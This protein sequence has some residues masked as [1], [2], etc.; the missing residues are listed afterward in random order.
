MPENTL[1]MLA[2]GTVYPVGHASKLRQVKYEISV[3]IKN[4]SVKL[5]S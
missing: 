4:T 5:S 1:T 2:H 3:A